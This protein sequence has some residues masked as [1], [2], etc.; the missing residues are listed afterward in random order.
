MK[1]FPRSLLLIL[2]LILSSPVMPAGRAQQE[3]VKP[4]INKSYETTNAD[5]AVKRF[6]TESREIFKNRVKIVD[7]CGL[8]PGMVVADIGAGTGLFTR[9]M[10]PKVGAEGKVFAVDITKHFLEHIAETCKEQKI[11]N[12]QTVLC[13]PT[14]TELPA[15]SV[16]LVFI[17]DVYHHFEFPYKSLA[18]I[19][20]A[21][22]G[23]GRLILIDFKRKEGT[24]AKWVMNHVRAGKK[25][26]IEEVTKAGFKLVDEPQMMKGQYVL[27]FVKK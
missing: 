2:A 25:T 4:G 20:Q 26:V 10:A 21:M 5:Q 15:D 14:S 12:V 9:L 22:H 3:S 8:K 13:T 11:E 24:N 19:H 17:C 6:E 7:M 27:R 16:D 23:D 18:S 1:I